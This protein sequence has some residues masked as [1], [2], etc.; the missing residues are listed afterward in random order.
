MLEGVT[1]ALGVTGCSEAYEAASLAKELVRRGANVECIMTQAATEFI[2]RVTLQNICK[3][4]V[5]LDAFA[6]PKEW[7]Q[8]LKSLSQ[9]AQVL[10]VAPASVNI[11]GKAACGI[12]DDLLSTTIVSVTC[13]VL[14]APQINPMMAS[15]PVIAR[16]IA[17][18][19]ADG[20]I[21]LGEETFAREGHYA[22]PTA[23]EL[24]DA[25]EQALQG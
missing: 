25:V 21:I 24:A 15:K 4:P 10:L 11:L 14:F 22:L 6:E 18:I 19:K 3:R 16:N 2:G 7:V 9:R 20:G 1:I 12:A 8:G 17:Q 23:Q 13:P 5:L